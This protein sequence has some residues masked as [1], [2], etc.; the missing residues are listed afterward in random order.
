MS[1]IEKGDYVIAQ[2]SGYGSRVQGYGTVSF[3]RG[4][5]LLVTSIRQSGLNVRKASGGSVFR[6]AWKSVAKPARALGQVPEGG[7]EIDDPRIQW[8]FED[9]GRLA[10]RFGYCRVYEQIT[11][12]LGAP[13]RERNFTI[14][15]AI[16]DGVEVTAKVLARSK[17]LA[18]QELRSRFG[19]TPMPEVKAIAAHG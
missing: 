1:E 9:A 5:E 7:I 19:A 6:I 8:L 18:E 4:D 15:L 13:G 14:K 12:M 3:E 16:A 17:R 10:D 2:V 11:E